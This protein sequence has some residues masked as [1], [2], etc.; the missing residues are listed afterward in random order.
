MGLFLL[1]SF[2]ACTRVETTALETTA[3]VTTTTNFKTITSAT[4]VVSVTTDSVVQPTA[5][6]IDYHS[7]HFY[8]YDA[9]QSA[10]SGEDALKFQN[11]IQAEA[12]KLIPLYSVL[13]NKDSVPIP[14]LN[15]TILPLQEEEN[16][17]IVLFDIER[18]D[19]PTIMYRCNYEGRF[20]LLR[21]TYLELLDIELSE[22]VTIATLSKALK[23]LYASPE[24]YQQ[25]ENV[26]FAEDKDIT[27][28]GESV[29]AR[30]VDYSD[31][32]GRDMISYLYHDLLICI[33]SPDF[34][35]FYEEFFAGFSV[36]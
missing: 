13:K 23:P 25:Y 20:I 26:D 15:D 3:L 5:P 33:E 32:Y 18:F 4:T 35:E 19:A 11:T 21:V 6:W 12:P 29:L 10:I 22:G 8:S 9:F 16:G 24:N 7:Y 2:V 14:Y 27:V 28:N 31:S 36:K 1:A 17:F 30:I 34:L